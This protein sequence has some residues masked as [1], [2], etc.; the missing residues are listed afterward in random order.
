M[1]KPERDRQNRKALRERWW[2]YA[3]KR[4]GLYA[5]I[6]GLGR[7]L[8]INCGATPQFGIAFLPARMVFA[9]TLDVFPFYTHAT[10]CTLQSRPHE[11][12]A[13]FFG[14]SMKDD[15]RYTP[16]DCFETFPSLTAGKPTQPSKPLARRTTSTDPPSW[17]ETTRA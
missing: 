3:E 5:A 2:H 8:V 1:A 12:W 7:V 11:I 6:A 9:N 10:F 14:S 17:S 15:L 13:R 4:P 16:S